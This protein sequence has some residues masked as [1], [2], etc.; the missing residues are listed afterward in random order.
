MNKQIKL[1]LLLLLTTV[2]FSGCTQT[3]V[4]VFDNSEPMYTN[5][6]D[7][8]TGNLVGVQYPFST[9]GNSVFVKDLDLLN[10][11]NNNFT[12]NIT[13]YFNNLSSV[14]YDNTTNN[15][16]SITV[17]FKKSLQVNRIGFGCNDLNNNFSNIKIK[18]LGSGQEVRYIN[19]K[20]VNNNTKRNSFLI[21]I[22]PSALNGFTI[23]FHT[24]DTVCLSNIIIF[25]VNDV[26]ARIQGL[27][28]DG[29]LGDVILS[30]T[31][32]LK[33]VSQP[34]TYAIAEG[35]I[36]GHYPLLKFGTR[37]LVTANTQSLIW[38]GPT[39]LYVDLPT[40]QQLKVSSTSLLDTSTGTG[41]R[42]LYIYG[43]N[44]TYEEVTEILTLNGTG[45]VTTTN[46][47]LR[48]SR[49]AVYTSGSL[50]TNA[51]VISIK[52]NAGTVT[53]ALINIGDGQ[54][55]MSR[56]TVPRCKT[57][58]IVKASA[59]TDSN[60]GS[61][62]SLFT[63]KLNN[64][65]QYP[66]LIKYRGFLFSGA[67]QIPVDIPYVIPEKTDIEMRVL[68][69]TSAGTTSVGGTFELWYEENEVCN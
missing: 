10:S 34:Y 30:N 12:G 51:G 39:D 24:I 40:A 46:S 47:Y 22:T 27:K 4:A 35:D 23:E 53:Q 42:T 48:V 8:N 36:S 58:Y 55:L 11:Y 60:K 69:P 18:G 31:G 21:D 67:I 20:Y 17:Y 28:D 63:R 50:Y 49:A 26:N 25:K 37:T 59:S 16:K 43:L 45:I 62:L 7:S 61:R 44:S 3:S 15:I 56:W 52:N 6:I 64:G 68:T 41:V 14:N 66:W 2:L 1:L 32:R 29:T 57:A 13:D 65:T 5:I 54:T 9:D 33:T 19:D 38:E